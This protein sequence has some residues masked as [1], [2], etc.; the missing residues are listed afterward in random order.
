VEDHL[1]NFP[2]SK[3]NNRGKVRLHGHPAKE[4]LELD[5]AAG[6]ADG[7][8]PAELKKTRP[9]YQHFDNIQWSKAVHREKAKQREAHVWVEAR[10]REGQRRHIER[11][12][13]MLKEAGRL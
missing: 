5:V 1:K 2:P 13:A 3:I 12:T 11:R 10:N 7:K 4:L 9:E 8:K 6:D